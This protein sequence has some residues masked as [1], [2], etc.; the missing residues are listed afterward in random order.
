MIHIKSNTHLLLLRFNNYKKYSF[1]D[2]HLRYV[3][4]D[5]SVWM[6]KIG[7]KIP[8]AK[9]QD[10]LN[11]GGILILKEPKIDG[12][13]YYVAH[14]KEYLYGAATYEMSFPEYYYEMAD[15]EMIWNMEEGLFG[16]WLHVD[17]IEPLPKDFV[18]NLKLLSNGK[19]VEDVLSHTMSSMMYIQSKQDYSSK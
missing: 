10:V 14:I 3:K 16:T 8:E 18:P 2:E 19:D 17:Q 5:G 13:K 4:D 11:Q 6:L 15:D 12:G 1:L 7:R 9:I